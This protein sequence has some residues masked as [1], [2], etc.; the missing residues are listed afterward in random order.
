M[1]YV[2]WS[3]GWGLIGTA[4]LCRVLYLLARE[5]RRWPYRWW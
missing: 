2:S 5:L 1:P 4:I 3:F